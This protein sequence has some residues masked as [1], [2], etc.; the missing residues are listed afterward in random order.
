MFFLDINTSIRKEL[1]DD[2]RDGRLKKQL[3]LGL[4]NM[5]QAASY[6]TTSFSIN[7]CP[8]NKLVFSSIRLLQEREKK[9][10]SN[11]H[12]SPPWSTGGQ[13]LCIFIQTTS[14]YVIF[15]QP[16]GV[17][18]TSSKL[19]SWFVQENSWPYLTAR[20]PLWV[21][22]NSVRSWEDPCNECGTSRFETCSLA[23]QS[24]VDV[25][26]NSLW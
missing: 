7:V 24:A 13:F 3:P 1:L 21:R 16:A 17:L 20:W 8:N 6:L 11:Y 4:R 14:I 26:L 19:H 18:I 5:L 2:F 23:L 25:L 15:L 12:C 9:S 22:I 10:T